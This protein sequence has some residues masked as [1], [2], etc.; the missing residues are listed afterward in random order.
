M[1]IPFTSAA[2]TVTIVAFA[3]EMA[4][5]PGPYQAEAKPVVPSAASRYLPGLT[6]AVKTPAAIEV[7]AARF[8]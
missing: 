6:E 7:S 8:P 5:P 1:P 3:E 2:A 4:K